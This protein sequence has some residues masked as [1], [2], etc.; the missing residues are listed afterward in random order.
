MVREV[1]GYRMS[2]VKISVIIPVYNRPGM[3]LRA[4]DSVFEQSFRDFEVLVVDDGSTDLTRD[5]INNYLASSGPSDIGFRLIGSEHCGMPGKNRNIAAREADGEYLAFLDS[6]D[7][8]VP[9]KLARQLQSIQEQGARF[10]HTEEVWIR[11]D[12]EVSQSHRKHLRQ[13]DMFEACLKMCVIGPSTVM[14]ERALFLETGGF[15]EDL[16][17]CEDYE[18]WLR[19]TAEQR[20]GWCQDQLTIKH[21]GHEDQLSYKYEQIEIFR[22]VGLRDLVESGAFEPEQQRLA[23]RELA[24]K[25]RYYAR[26]CRKRGRLEEAAEYEGIADRQDY[27]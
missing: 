25:C 12:K 9:D 10:S 16:E 21:G 4:L 24:R 5:A 27:V 23:S 2:R 11:N 22:I 18:Y 14:I 1:S 19:L 6:D 8:W 26:G 15:R 7:L 3:V 13:G 17:I 20:V